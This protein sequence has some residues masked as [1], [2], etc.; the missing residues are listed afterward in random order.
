[1]S[2]R[3]SKLLAL[4]IAIIALVILTLWWTMPRPNKPRL[5]V[6]YIATINGNG[7][8]RL[9]FGVT[10]IGNRTIVTYKS[11]SI[12]VIGHSNK[13]LVG[14]TAPLL[15]LAPGEGHIIDAVLSEQQMASLDGP[16]RYTCLYANDNFRTRMNRGEFG[17]F[18]YKHIPR[19]WK[20]VPLTVT[21]TSDWIKESK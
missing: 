15:R 14:A 9:K 21:G 11:G 2:R 18:I 20:G 8:W 10:N 3:F 16:W 5:S 12:E 17:A 7:H 4:F 13:F 19:P 1:M 6:T